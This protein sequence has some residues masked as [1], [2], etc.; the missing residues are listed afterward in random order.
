MELAA[1]KVSL[2]KVNR[3]PKTRTTA[4]SLLYV[5]LSLSSVIGLPPS[6]NHRPWLSILGQTLRLAPAPHG[7]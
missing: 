4:K 3:T 6:E 7:S 2:P 5:G 1:Y